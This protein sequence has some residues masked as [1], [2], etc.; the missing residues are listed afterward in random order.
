MRRKKKEGCERRRVIKRCD[1][2][3]VDGNKG[4]AGVTREDE[5]VS[6]EVITRRTLSQVNLHE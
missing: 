1:K 2:G 3:E 5:I 4:K 6:C